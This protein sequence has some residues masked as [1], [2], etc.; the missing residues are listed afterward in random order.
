MS[1]FNWMTLA[2]VAFILIVIAAAVIRKVALDKANAAGAA[3]RQ[4]L[5]AQ[6]AGGRW[7]TRSA[8]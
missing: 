3:G 4:Q 5:S 7:T 6:G 2:P 1:D 8:G